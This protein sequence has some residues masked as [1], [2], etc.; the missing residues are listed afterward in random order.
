MLTIIIAEGEKTLCEVIES[1]HALQKS[2]PYFPVFRRESRTML[3]INDSP[4]TSINLDPKTRL[5]L[6]TWRDPK[7]GHNLHIS[8]V[9]DEGGS[10]ISGWDNIGR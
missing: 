8:R 7:E 5:M 6:T 2:E 1:R 3:S 10:S 4:I 9:M